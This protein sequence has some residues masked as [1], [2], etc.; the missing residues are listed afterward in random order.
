M[1]DSYGDAYGDGPPAAPPDEPKLSRAQR[2]ALGRARR[3]VRS[4]TG[5]GARRD[6]SAALDAAAELRRATAG[7]SPR[8]TPKAAN[9]RGQRR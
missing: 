3:A 7:G 8:V 6:K 1:E 5:S 2:R 4:F 9:R